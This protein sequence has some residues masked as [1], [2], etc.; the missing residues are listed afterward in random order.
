MAFYRHLSEK[1]RGEC[2]RRGFSLEL[3]ELWWAGPDDESHA[4]R[5]EIDM[6]YSAMVRQGVKKM[7]RAY[8]AGLDY[9]Q[10]ELI[11]QQRLQKL[12]VRISR[13][14]EAN[15]ENPEN[16]AERR[17]HDLIAEYGPGQRRGGRRIFSLRRNASPMPSA[18]WPRKR[19]RPC[20]RASAL[21]PT[22]STT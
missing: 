4:R 5:G 22:R 12:S 1:N 2:V 19:R 18:P 15:F 21:R 16:A 20:R 11:F 14:F 17:I 7:L 10:I 8:K 13:A 3:I 6:C 9:G